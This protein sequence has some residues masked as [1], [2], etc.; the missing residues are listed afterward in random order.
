MVICNR[1]EVIYISIK[2]IN[3]I[4][5][6]SGC[7]IIRKDAI[8]KGEFN[9]QLLALCQNDNIVNILS[10]SEGKDYSNTK[11]NK[12]AATKKTV[13]TLIYES[14]DGLCD[15]KS[16][17]IKKITMYKCC[18]LINEFNNSLLE[19]IFFIEIIDNK[20][21]KY[22][23]YMLDQSKI[24]CNQIKLLTYDYSEIDV[25]YEKGK[26]VIFERV[27]LNF[28]DKLKLFL[29]CIK[30]NKEMKKD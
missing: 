25:L 10:M 2:N 12:I 22:Y 7:E 29:K 27:V 15:I 5:I 9:L 17:N 21:N 30:F 26:K 4:I 8:P 16:N 19:A 3:K 11:S 14:K 23:Y 18:S 28:F 13:N 1:R 24:T 20:N 6:I